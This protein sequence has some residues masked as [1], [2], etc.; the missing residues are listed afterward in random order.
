MQPIVRGA[1]ARI[2]M[3][4]RLCISVLWRGEEKGEGMD[5]SGLPPGGRVSSC[6]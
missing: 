5:I 6:R 3:A 2:R 4:R 1:A